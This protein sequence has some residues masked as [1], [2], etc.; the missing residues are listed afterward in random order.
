MTLMRLQQDWFQPQILAL[1]ISQH[2]LILINVPTQKSAKQVAVM[3]WNTRDIQVNSFRQ[4]FFDTTTVQVSLT[5]C[6]L[7]SR[8]LGE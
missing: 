7:L 3:F 5:Q 6:R 1:S 4:G 2:Q 8:E